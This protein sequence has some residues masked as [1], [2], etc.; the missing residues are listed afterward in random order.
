[1]NFANLVILAIAAV[2]G[3]SLFAM[4]YVAARRRRVLRKAQ[5]ISALRHKQTETWERLSHSAAGA[6]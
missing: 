4:L 3:I 6:P 5:E 1:M 2:V